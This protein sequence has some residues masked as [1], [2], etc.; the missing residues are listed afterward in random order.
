M[1]TSFSL[2]PVM[3]EKCYPTLSHNYGCKWIKGHLLICPKKIDRYSWTNNLVWCGFIPTGGDVDKSQV[4]IA[5][6][7]QTSPPQSKYIL[8]NKLL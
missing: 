2:C 7:A 5:L 3:H 4:F 1:H 8:I 6:A